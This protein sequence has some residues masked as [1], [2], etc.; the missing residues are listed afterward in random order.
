MSKQSDEQRSQA[1][2]QL[3]TEKPCSETKSKRKE[4]CRTKNK[5]TARGGETKLHSGSCAN[6]L[7]AQAKR[8]LAGAPSKSR[9]NV[10]RIVEVNYS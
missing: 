3:G 10:S 1:E 4:Q 2:E 7:K 5:T 9:L 8:R 6:L